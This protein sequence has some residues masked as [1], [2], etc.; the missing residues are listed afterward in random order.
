MF[1]PLR[2]L[3]LVRKDKV[4][5]KCLKEPLVCYHKLLV[6]LRVVFP[7]WWWTKAKSRYSI[8]S[9]HSAHRYKL[10]MT[11]GI[12]VGPSLDPE[13]W[14]K[15]QNQATLQPG[16]WPKKWLSQGTTERA[17]ARGVKLIVTRG[18]MSLIVAFK[19]PNV[20]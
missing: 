9:P 4:T 10:V 17:F 1:S 14:S 19:G 2:A 18:H 6:F 5:N 3:C 20:F 16:S 15:G 7:G 12:S 11:V 8:P 13:E